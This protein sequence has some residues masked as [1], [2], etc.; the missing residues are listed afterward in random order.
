MNAP[1][2][3]SLLETA[4]YVGDLAR[5]EEFYRVI[6]GLEP[7]FEPG[8][9]QGD[10]AA[11]RLRAFRLPGNAVLLLF[12]MGTT[13]NTLTTAEGVIPGHAATG[14]IHLA[15]AVDSLEGWREH[16]ADHGVAIEGEFH[17]PRGG[18]SWYFRDPDQ[19]L[20]ELATPGVWPSY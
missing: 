4:I 17:W 3:R 7:M 19:N 14:R 2:I 20:L 6:F 5:A 11:D 10:A 16:L 13:S 12:R 9:L 8:D 1:R 18:T 15:F